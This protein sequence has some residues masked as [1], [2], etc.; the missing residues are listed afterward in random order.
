MIHGDLHDENILLLSD[1]SSDY[2]SSG[3]SSSRGHQGHE[4]Y[5]KNIFGLIDFEDLHQSYCVVDIATVLSY[6]MIASKC[7][8]FLEVSEYILSGYLNK[9]SLADYEWK[10][11]Y[12]LVC[13]RYIQELVLCEVEVRTQGSNEY[14]KTCFKDGWP[15]I[16]YLL[17]MGEEHVLKAW[18][19]HCF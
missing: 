16:E 1:K 3:V 5:V 17:S 9:V 7:D 13:G 15:Q 18:Q 10:V 4:N 14:L 19:K 8:N 2:C 12:S 11:L 6:F